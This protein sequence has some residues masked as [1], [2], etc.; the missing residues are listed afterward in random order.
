MDVVAANVKAPASPV[1]QPGPIQR[2]SESAKRFISSFRGRTVHG[3]EV[4]PPKGY[5]GIVLRGDTK[6]THTHQHEVNPSVVPYEILVE[7][8]LDEMSLEDEE[9]P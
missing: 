7:G 1:Q 3:V 9:N 6:P 8:R 5:A 4:T 2:L